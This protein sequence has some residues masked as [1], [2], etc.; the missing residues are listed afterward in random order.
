[1]RFYEI[2]GTVKGFEE[3][4]L[5]EGEQATL[6]RFGSGGSLRPQ[7]KSRT[8]DFNA[9][10]TGCFIAVSELSA[11]KVALC[12]LTE[13]ERDPVAI[14]RDYLN[15]VGIASGK[16]RASE[17]TFSAYRR[18]LRRSDR[19]DVI[20]DDDI[21]FDRFNLIELV[22]S[23]SSINFEESL[24]APA[25]NKSMDSLCRNLLTSSALKQEL[26][27]IRAS[28]GIE[29][30]KGH[31]VHY[32][33]KTSDD[34]T[35]AQSSNILLGSLMKSGRLKTR[36]FC[37]VAL[38]E[39]YHP[40]RSSIENLFT[41]SEGGVILLDVDTKFDLEDDRSS[42]AL[43]VID[44]LCTCARMFRNSVLT[45]WRLPVNSSQVRSYLFEQMGAM[46]FVELN[47][48]AA[49]APQAKRLLVHFAQ[50]CNLEPDERLFEKLEKNETYLAA[51]LRIMLEEWRSKKLKTDVYPQYASFETV[52][53]VEAKK[54]SRG[55]AHEELMSL[56]GLTDAKKV[57]NGAIDFHRIQKFLLSKDVMRDRPSYHM[58]FTG[59]PGSAKTT[60]ARLFGRIMRENDLLESGHVVEV[61]RADL[62]GRYV[63]HTA[64][65]VQKCF[66][67]AKGGVLFI[68][69]AYSLLDDRDGCFGDEAI[70][71]IVQEMENHRDSVAVIFAGYPDKMRQFLQK[72]PGLSSR[73]SFHVDFPDYSTEELCEIA[74]LISAKKGLRLSVDAREKLSE[75]FDGARAKSDFG[76]GRY[77]RSAI[78][79]AMIA[80]ATRLASGDLDSLKKSDF[81]TIV[82]EDIEVPEHAPTEQRRIGFCA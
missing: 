37:T 34:E 81:A 52:G 25:S 28:K 10:M 45:V 75:L 30:I 20:E 79:K 2:T 53:A 73:I 66:E 71:T 33:I 70:N 5:E 17:L 62:V 74:S 12:L 11:S 44:K 68:D 69:E 24:L 57:I 8:E 72:N 64:P 82:A 65:L 56:V 16:M 63:G 15:A 39:N 26:A 54:D 21:V 7:L 47:E 48:E 49:A 42:A 9:E 77:V 41:M 46:S 22:R 38:S 36:R 60:V 13:E 50:E 43:E 23:C 27:R 58:L 31:P 32:V 4:L 51:E 40:S 6:G 67:R 80:Q 14:S 35:C 19:Y 29:G 76:N 1:M 18:L 59:N 61:G 55:S 78:E 3:G